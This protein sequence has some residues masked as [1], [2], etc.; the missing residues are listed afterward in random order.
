MKIIKTV[1]LAGKITGDEKYRSKFRAAATM[2]EVAGFAV[3][4]PATLP[5]EGFE[6]AAY[7]RMSAAMLIE[8][9]AACFLSDWKDSAGARDEHEMAKATGKDIFY[10]DEW[11]HKLNG[12]ARIA[13][14]EA[15][16]N[17]LQYA[18]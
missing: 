12:A 2:L 9:D 16:G 1:Y 11:V 18:T 4:N 5:P 7:M 10:F 3:L 17:G 8:C 14:R 13:S 15:V 6:Y